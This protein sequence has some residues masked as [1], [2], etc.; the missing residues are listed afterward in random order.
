MRN[1]RIALLFLAIIA[2]M[3][4]CARHEPPSFD[5]AT[6]GHGGASAASASARPPLDDASQTADGAAPP[7]STPTPPHTAVN[8]P[9]SSTKTQP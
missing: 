8:N 6:P 9:P 3:G 4:A 2:S 5:A 1:S 7:A